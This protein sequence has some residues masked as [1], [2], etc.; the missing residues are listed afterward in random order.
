MVDPL[1]TSSADALPAGAPLHAASS[2]LQRVRGQLR[3]LQQRSELHLRALRAIGDGVVT[4]D[5]GGRIQFMNPVAAHL[6]GWREVDAVGRP[7]EDVLAF[8]DGC[9]ER[10]DLRQPKR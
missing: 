2:E 4:V 8:S 1:R 7:V 5:R 9:G 3:A 10:I 6:C